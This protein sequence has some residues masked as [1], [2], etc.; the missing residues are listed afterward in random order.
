MADKQ[1]VQYSEEKESGTQAPAQAPVSPVKEKYAKF[2]EEPVA[3][4]ESRVRLKD[5]PFPGAP[6]GGLPKNAIGANRQPLL[7]NVP[8]T[9]RQQQLHVLAAKRLEALN[10]KWVADTGLPP[11]TVASGWRRRAFKDFAAYHEY[12]K[13]NGYWLPAQ[14]GPGVASLT[15]T[16][17]SNPNRRPS[18][19]KKSQGKCTISKA[20]LSAHELGL[21]MDF[22]NNGL[23]PI[24]AS[25]SRQKTERSFQWLKENAHL[26]GITPYIREAWHWEVKMPLESWIT[27]E[28][29]VEGDNYAVRVKGTG[30]AGK[31][32]AGVAAGVNAASKCANRGF[33]GG[34][35]T[36]G[37]NIDLKNYSLATPEFP[38]VKSGTEFPGLR[39]RPPE[40][41][42]RVVIHETAGGFGNVKSN[43]EGGDPK[44]VK[45]LLKRGL[46]T[47]FTITRTGAVRQHASTDKVAIHG[48]GNPTSIGI[49]LVNPVSVSKKE[50]KARY[51]NK[52]DSDTA[53][54]ILDR[55]LLRK[56]HLLNTPE[57]CEALW[58]L[59]K[60][61]VAKHPN[62]K[63]QFPCADAGGGSFKT[64]KDPRHKNPGIIAH[65]RDHHADGVF[66]EYFCVA[67]SKGLSKMQAWYAA[68][69]AAATHGDKGIPP[70]PSQGNA[71]SLGQLGRD[72]LKE[73]REKYKKPSE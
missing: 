50:T 51:V 37:P 26:F 67:R 22:G 72:K 12:C 24:M 70:M 33:V 20:Y 9:G 52:S 29:W 39:D 25:N 69:G 43:A 66:S 36:A 13:R 58:Q 28:E 46:S 5:Y 18:E 11:L 57:Q 40:Q 2:T 63:M 53:Y 7:V 19:K 41:V 30:K 47:H 8:S 15:D 48:P 59:L 1:E 68:V 31:V 60:K 71:A 27:G 14:Y 64:G 62:L 54:P 10:R 61:L 55:G 17:P 21:A 65:Q 45:T 6:D 42:T 35:N 56:G 4:K 44:A 73:T 49:D 16:H 34:N 3:Y 38:G 23:E 32:A